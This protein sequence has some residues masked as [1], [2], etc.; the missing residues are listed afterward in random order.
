MSPINQDAV[1]RLLNAQTGGSY[2]VR[3][4]GEVGYVATFSVSYTWEGQGFSQDS[5][6]FTVGE[7]RT[8]QVPAG[9]TNIHLEGKAYVSFSITATVFTRDFAQ[10]SK[11][12][13][14]VKGL[15]PTYQPVSC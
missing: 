12:C 9:A 4:D 13:W 7:S 8:I 11:K 3:N 15:P 10:P 1:T 6:A 2:S 5:G 14:V